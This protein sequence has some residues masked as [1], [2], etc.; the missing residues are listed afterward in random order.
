MLWNGVVISCFSCLS[1]SFYKSW[2]VIEE[3][4]PTEL[5]ESSVLIFFLRSDGLV[6]GSCLDLSV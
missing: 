2:Y 5:Q 1:P 6:A 4:N 3:R